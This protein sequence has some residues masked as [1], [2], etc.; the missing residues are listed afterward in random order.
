MAEVETIDNHSLEGRFEVYVRSFSG[1]GETI[2]VSREG[3]TQPLWA[4]SGKELFFRTL[5]SSQ[6]LAV[7]ILNN[8]NFSVGKPRL[9]FE[10]RR[11]VTSGVVRGYDISL[12]DQRFL[13]VKNEERKPRPVT[14]LILIQNW[15][16]ELKRLAPT[17]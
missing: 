6:V 2:K 14:E 16:E 3:G 9:L 12:D 10:K 11:S 7:D 15:F 17:K 4:R 13:M 5:E 8:T 1:G